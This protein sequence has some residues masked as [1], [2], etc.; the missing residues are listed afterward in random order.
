MHA[1]GAGMQRVPAGQ[2]TAAH[3]LGVSRVGT[4]LVA[5]PHA[6]N[7][8]QLDVAMHDACRAELRSQHTAFVH[9]S[10]VTENWHMDDDPTAAMEAAHVES[11][12]FGYTGAS[13]MKMAGHA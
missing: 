1:L 9:T 5:P 10:G 12:G 4:V 7:P 3:T 2:V 13:M 11:A 6:V 8:P